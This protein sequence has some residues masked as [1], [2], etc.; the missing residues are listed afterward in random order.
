MRAHHRK[1]CEI[2]A[3]QQECLHRA[4]NTFRRTYSK[5]VAHLQLYHIGILEVMGFR[6]HAEVTR[7]SSCMELQAFVHWGQLKCGC[8]EFP[9]VL[10]HAPLPAPDHISDYGYDW[11]E[12]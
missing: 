2:N 5:L 12:S 10:G 11:L 9:E 8:T 4:R 6:Y 3:Q 1:T 7:P